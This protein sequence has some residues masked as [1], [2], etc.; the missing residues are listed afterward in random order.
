MDLNRFLKQTVVRWQSNGRSVTGKLSF[1]TGSELSARWE[2]KKE[3]FTDANGEQKLSRAV[4]YFSSEISEGDFIYLGLFSGLTAAQQSDPLQVDGAQE[5][6]Q[7]EKTPNLKG[8]LFL[9]KAY[10]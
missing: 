10:L 9:Y 7:V 3:L 2:G 8:T 5:I 4:V 1:G 6:R